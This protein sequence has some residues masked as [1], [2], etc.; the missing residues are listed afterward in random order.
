MTCQDFN[1]TCVRRHIVRDYFLLFRK[2]W[3][4]IPDNQIFCCQHGSRAINC[5]ADILWCSLLEHR[6]TSSSSENAGRPQEAHNTASTCHTPR[7]GSGGM[8][9]TSFRSP[10]YNP[11]HVFVFLF[12]CL[13]LPVFVASGVCGF[14]YSSS[15]D[16]T[17]FRRGS[18]SWS[19]EHRGGGWKPFS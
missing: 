7:C 11:L 10:K 17:A 1:R 12:R 13:W 9:C 6:K 18:E 16:V 14:R 3:F 8:V 15:S 2:S 19:C 5:V 4:Y